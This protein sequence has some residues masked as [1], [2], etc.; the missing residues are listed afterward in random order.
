MEKDKPGGETDEAKDDLGVES[1]QLDTD[2]RDVLEDQQPGPS[3]KIVGEV[4]EEGRLC[5]LLREYLH[6]ISGSGESSLEIIRGGNLSN[7]H[8]NMLATHYFLQVKFY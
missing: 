3:D 6:I 4:V 1:E 7:L 2:R 5:I 8:K